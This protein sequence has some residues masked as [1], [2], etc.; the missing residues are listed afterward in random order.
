MDKGYRSAILILLSL[1]ALF[2]GIQY[3][4]YSQMPIISKQCKILNYT[5]EIK[6]CEINEI[7]TD[8]EH[9]SIVFEWNNVIKNDTIISTLNTKS[10]DKIECYFRLDD[11]QTLTLKYIVSDRDL[12]LFS[13]II[14]SVVVFPFTFG[15]AIS[16]FI[17]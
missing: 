11:I 6:L 16:E 4:K 9:I 7:Y 2:K 5:K 13:S 10:L 15:G 12:Y 14:L 8:C 1:F 3:F 17:N